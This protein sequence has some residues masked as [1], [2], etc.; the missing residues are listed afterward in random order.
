[1]T[2]RILIVEDEPDMRR[3]LQDNLEFEDYE[4]VTT[5]NGNE[6]L[7]LAQREHFD[8]II[9]DIMLPGL[10]GMEVC[11]QLKQS[12]N[13]T[14]VIMLTARGSEADRVEGLEIGADDY[15]TK[16]FSLRE[17]LARVKAILRRT[18]GEGQSA[19]QQ[20]A[21]GD[22]SID[23]QRNQASKGGEAL[24]LS[25]REFQMLRFM[26]ENRNEILSREAFLREVWGYENFPNT[27]TVDNHIVKL[28][29]KVED[30]PEHPR[31]ILTAPRQGY[32]FVP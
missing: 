10:D 30:D 29:Q 6:G 9:L 17:M 1:M 20:F 31:H 4:A 23:F 15:I 32:K 16:P 26:I 18:S 12:G 7:R 3:G 21:F 24:D 5:S 13:E 14:P 22:V 27:R 19:L 11:R 25:M 28:R 8:L 2:H